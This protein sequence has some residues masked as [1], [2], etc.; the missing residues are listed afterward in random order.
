MWVA[1]MRDVISR[2]VDVSGRDWRLSRVWAQWRARTGAT[3][4]VVLIETLSGLGVGRN[5]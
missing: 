1:V 5:R 3:G 4:V 2:G